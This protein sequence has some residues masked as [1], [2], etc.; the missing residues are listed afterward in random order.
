[1]TREGYDRLRRELEA[2]T[3][4][5]RS[6]VAERLRAARDHGGNP[7]E[8]GELMDAIDE[9]SL[10]EQR[11]SALET[12]LASARVVAAAGD[13]TAG[14]GT[15]VRLRSRTAGIVEYELVG[16]GEADPGGGRISIDSPVGRAIAGRRPGETIEVETPRRVRRLELLSVEP[17]ETG[18]GLAQAA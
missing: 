14:M 13:G 15:R 7:A 9:Q 16:A 10:L 6:D 12:R 8:N 18:A 17:V 4:T 1:M 5:A 3:T 2:L 11:I